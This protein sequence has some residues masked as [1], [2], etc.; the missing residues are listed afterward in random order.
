MNQAADTMLSVARRD[1]HIM[2]REARK[3]SVRINRSAAEAYDLLSLPEN[4]PKWASGLGAS[5]RR[6]GDD[7]VVETPEGP[8]SVRFSERNAYGVLDHS[9]KLPRGASIYV[10]LRVVADGDGCELVLTLFRQPD[11]S[12]EKFAADAEWVMRDLHAAKRLLEDIR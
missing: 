3:L 1:D 9:V 12:D 8:A 5:L 2:A 6:E 7:W 11:V 4:F 10:P